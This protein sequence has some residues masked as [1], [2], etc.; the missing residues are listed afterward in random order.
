MFSN[1]W[2]KA[3]SPATDSSKITGLL[4]WVGGGFALLAGIATFF[5]IKDGVLARVVRVNPSATLAILILV[6]IGVILALTIPALDPERKAPLWLVV[7]GA[8]VVVVATIIWSPDL[9]AGIAVSLPAYSGVAIGA[10]LLALVLGLMAAPTKT[11]TWFVALVVIAVLSLGGGLYIAAKLSVLEKMRLE[12][13]AVVATISTKE[14]SHDV[15]LYAAGSE[16]AGPV[17]VRV[18]GV[19]PNGGA[20][21]AIGEQVLTP[22]RS[23]SLEAK[24][25]IPIPGTDWLTIKVMTCQEW[26]VNQRDPCQPTTLQSS[27]EFSPQ[28][29][30]LAATPLIAEDGKSITFKV[31]GSGFSGGQYVN[32]AVSSSDK[33]VPFATARVRAGS[34]GTVNWQVSATAS[35]SKFWRAVASVCGPNNSGPDK[36]SKEEQLMSTTFPAG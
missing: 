26:N 8:G 27:F 15:E 16:V 28:R 19:R 17:R 4:Q 11:I 35:E 7:L 20:E 32:I 1:L 30:G 21:E 24:T 23:G 14:G 33:T 9:P 12:S 10:I 5:G 18:L 25:S 22:S 6:G 36:C 3:D 34:E 2:E 31:E 29:Y 13:A